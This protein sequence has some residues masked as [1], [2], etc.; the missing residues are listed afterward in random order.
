MDTTFTPHQHL[1]T[2]DTIH[3]LA[4]ATPAA[5]LAPSEL[6]VHQL[7]RLVPVY[8]QSWFVTLLVM[9]GFVTGTTFLA[10]SLIVLTGPVYLPTPGRNGRLKTWAQWEVDHVDDIQCNE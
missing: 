4:Y 5:A 6:S 8:R 3:P 7:Y 10:A 9:L 1:E 2:R